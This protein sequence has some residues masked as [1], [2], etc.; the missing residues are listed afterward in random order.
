MSWSVSAVGKPAAVSAKI[1]EDVLKYTC[2]EPEETLK[3]SA[4]AIIA[5][6]LAA[7]PQDNIAVRVE[8]NG[9]Q[10]PWYRKDG[11]VGEGFANTLRV[12]IEPVWGFVE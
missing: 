6:A 4:A 2:S 5:T 10:Q 3:K 7:F 11:T 12:V 9:S 8:A 1:S